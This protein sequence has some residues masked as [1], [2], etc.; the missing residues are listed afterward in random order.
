MVLQRGGRDPDFRGRF[1]LDVNPLFDR[2]SSAYVMRQPILIERR[3][4]C[5]PW[6][7][8]SCRN[9]A[10]VPPGKNM[11]SLMKRWRNC[12][13]MF[14]T[15][16]ATLK[17]DFTMRRSASAAVYRNSFFS[18]R[19]LSRPSSLYF[20]L[21]ETFAAERKQLQDEIESRDVQIKELAVRFVSF[22]RFNRFS[23]S[24]QCRLFSQISVI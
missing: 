18:R 15:P 19:I 16:S 12:R 9:F 3:H 5:I 20:V 13:R 7:L 4:V 11:H 22:P 21:Q 14:G 6:N 23:P 8:F 10:A 24:S 2:M 1:I 17:S